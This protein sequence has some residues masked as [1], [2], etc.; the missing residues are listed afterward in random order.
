MARRIVTNNGV[1]YTISPDNDA[2]LA[3]RT[4]AIVSAL[5]VDEITGQAPGGAVTISA[6]EPGFQPRIAADGLVGLT[7]IPIS[8]FPKRLCCK[9]SQ[10]NQWPGGSP[11]LLCL[12]GR[13]QVGDEGDLPGD[14]SF[15]HSCDL[16]LPDHV[17]DLVALQ[18]S[19]CRFQRKEA[20]PGLDQPFDEAVILLD[21]VVQV[22]D[23]SQFDRLGKD[24]SC[25]E[26]YNGF[27]IGRIL[28]DIDDAGSRL[29]GVGSGRSPGLFHQRGR[30]CLD[31]D[32]ARSK[33]RGVGLN[34][35]RRLFHLLLERTRVRSRTSH[36]VQRF[37]K[38]AFGGLGIACRTQE[39]LE[40]VAF[41]VDGPVEI[42]PFFSDFDVGLVDFPGIVAGFEVRPAAFVQFRSVALYPPVNGGVVGLQSPFQHHLF[43]VAIAE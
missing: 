34:R 38:E 4:Q 41:R 12:G 2:P 23:L 40:G 32:H 25:F 1:L 7:G 6:A 24:S 3:A 9:N 10:K 30:V 42:H 15:A 43:E 11:F 33:L 19:P 29:R 39:K 27:G 31:R 37:L 22:F 28:I 18:R 8:R 20:H 21:Q 16:S 5:L 35:S 26:V 17:H 13:E 36:R 14:V